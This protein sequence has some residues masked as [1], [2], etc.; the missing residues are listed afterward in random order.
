MLLSGLSRERLKAMKD[1]NALNALY[2]MYAKY[3]NVIVKK[4]HLL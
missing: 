4:L 2:A 1:L 3:A